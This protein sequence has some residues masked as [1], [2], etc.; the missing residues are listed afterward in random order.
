[1][2]RHCKERLCLENMKMINKYEIQMKEGQRN[3]VGGMLVC[4]LML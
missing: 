2:R 1:M 4:L 3:K